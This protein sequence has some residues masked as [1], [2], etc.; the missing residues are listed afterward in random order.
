MKLVETEN[1]YLSNWERS[2]VGVQLDFSM[3]RASSASL[4]IFLGAG[5]GYPNVHPASA[6]N[7]S[8]IVPEPGAHL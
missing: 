5:N 3:A 7:Y 4:V 8:N 2:A 1:N 6:C